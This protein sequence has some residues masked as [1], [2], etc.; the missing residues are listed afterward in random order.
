MD[1]L[2]GEPSIRVVVR[3]ARTDHGNGTTVVPQ[4]ESGHQGLASIAR[5]AKDNLCSSPPNAGSGADDGVL[6]FKR[7]G[8]KGMG[9]P[10]DGVVRLTDLCG[11]GA[12]DLVNLQPGNVVNVLEVGAGCQ[13]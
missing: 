12:N 5:A 11:L 3:I 9:K 2:G 8:H 10:D 4:T 1:L 6:H 7:D 13:T